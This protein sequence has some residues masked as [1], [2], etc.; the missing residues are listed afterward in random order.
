M[1]QAIIVESSTGN[2]SCTHRNWCESVTM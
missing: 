2:V 1:N